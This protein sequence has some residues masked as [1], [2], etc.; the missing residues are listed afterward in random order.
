MMSYPPSSFHVAV[1]PGSL[2]WAAS[3]VAQ[4]LKREDA[5]AGA[6]KSQRVASS[7]FYQPNQSQAQ[8]ERKR[9]PSLDGVRLLQ[10]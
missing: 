6:Q 8:R 1:L 2:V 4:G 7:M 3:V 9:V 10:V 5:M